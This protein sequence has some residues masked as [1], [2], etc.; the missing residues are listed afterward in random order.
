MPD[1]GWTSVK[2]EMP[3]ISGEGAAD[4]SVVLRASPPIAQPPSGRGTGGGRVGSRA[5]LAVEGSGGAPSEG[6]GRASTEEN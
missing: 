1:G 4:V 2:R 3:R 6:L 5:A